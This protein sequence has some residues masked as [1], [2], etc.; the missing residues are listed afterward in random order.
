MSC[1]KKTVYNPIPSVPVYL[2]F[3]IDNPA[4]YKLENQGG[5]MYMDGGVR[6]LVVIHNY[7]DM[8]YAMDRACPYNYQDSCAQI[9]MENGS[10]F[11]KC[12]KYDTYDKNKWIPCCN[13]EFNLTGGIVSGPAQ[14]PMRAYKV[15]MSGSLVTISN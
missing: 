13:S 2:Q 3:N 10:L 6:G 14:Y 1:K 11:M 12:G 5:W 15:Q 8:I 7:D 4:Y 9:N